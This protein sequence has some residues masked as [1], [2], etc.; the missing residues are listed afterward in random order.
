M[1]FRAFVVARGSDVDA[2]M[3]ADEQRWFECACMMVFPL[4]NR[5]DDH[6]ITM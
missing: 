3:F 1:R 5:A 6:D 4:E 2:S